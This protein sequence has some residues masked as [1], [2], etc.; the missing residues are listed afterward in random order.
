MSAEGIRLPNHFNPKPR[1]RLSNRVRDIL[2]RMCRSK[3]ENWKDKYLFGAHV[4]QS[5]D[6]L[7]NGGF[8]KL[9]EAAANVRIRRFGLHMTDQFQQLPSPFWIASAMSN[10]QNTSQLLSK[11]IPALAMTTRFEGVLML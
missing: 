11:H 10:N 2:Q 8:R 7:L 3:E 1:R 4:M 9:K 5:L 6:R